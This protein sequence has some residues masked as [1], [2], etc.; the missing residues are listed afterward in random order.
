[1]V[2]H[3]KIRIEDPQTACK[4]EVRVAIEEALISA[5]VEVPTSLFSSSYF[6]R[7]AALDGLYHTFLSMRPGRTLT[8]YKR[9]V[10]EVKGIINIIFSL[11]M[12]YFK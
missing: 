12:E 1:M 2:K 6:E 11:I 8:D 3:A 5:G 7:K 9:N 4:Q 10:K